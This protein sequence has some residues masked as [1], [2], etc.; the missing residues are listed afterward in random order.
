[1]NSINFDTSTRGNWINTHEHRHLFM[2]FAVWSECVR[3]WCAT[4]IHQMAVA[5][6]G[7]HSHSVF[8]KWECYNMYAQRLSALSCARMYRLSACGSLWCDDIFVAI[9]SVVCSLTLMDITSNLC[10]KTLRNFVNLS[11]CFLCVCACIDAYFVCEHVF[12][13]SL[14][15]IASSLDSLN[16][17]ELYIGII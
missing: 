8:N 4:E 9:N 3:V 13:R 16:L 15:S 17:T 11:V 14:F 2:H 10:T 5:I 7:K 1:M 12:F 6:F